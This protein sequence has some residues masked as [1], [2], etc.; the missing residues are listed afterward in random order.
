MSPVFTGWGEWLL[1]ARSECSFEIVYIDMW[2]AK[3]HSSAEKWESLTFRLWF[4]Q[5]TQQPGAD[6]LTLERSFLSL[7]LWLY[8][9]CPAKLTFCCPVM[10]LLYSWSLA[11][12]ALRDWFLPFCVVFL[13]LH[14]PSL[15]PWL[16]SS[17][18]DWTQAMRRS[19]ALWLNDNPLYLQPHFSERFQH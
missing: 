3:Y 1:G 14:H 17:P 13:S 16:S 6:F 15:G 12:G 11:M 8:H 9:S 10:N 7:H 5:P 2:S 4:M 19:S 18:G